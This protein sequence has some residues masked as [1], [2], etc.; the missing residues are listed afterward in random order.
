[1]T[2]RSKAAHRR[3]GYLDW[4]TA[5]GG[6]LDGGVEI[7]CEAFGREAVDAIDDFAGAI[8]DHYGGQGIHFHEIVE[9][10]RVDRGNIPLFMGYELRDQGLVFVGIHGVEEDVAIP[11]VAFRYSHK[12]RFEFLARSA[13]GGPET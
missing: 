3:A 5:R 6:G 13:P 4:A 12:F 11:R 7:F 1:M 9:A 2:A 8:E 10:V